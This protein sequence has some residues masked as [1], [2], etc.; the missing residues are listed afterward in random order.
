MTSYIM[1][2]PDILQRWLFLTA[3]PLSVLTARMK[4]AA[5]GSIYGT[6]NISLQENAFCLAIRIDHRDCGE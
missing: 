3:N 5:R 4:V 1:F 2:V 6:G